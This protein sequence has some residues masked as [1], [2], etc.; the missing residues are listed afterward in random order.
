MM[1]SN[2]G[3]GLVKHVCAALDAGQ[4]TEDDLEARITRSFTLLMQAGLFDP[5]ELQM[6]GTAARTFDI[7]STNRFSRVSWASYH[8]PHMPCAV[9][10]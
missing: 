5:L 10:F 2:C 3:G 6:C 1:N 8:A 7:I 9:L 4:I